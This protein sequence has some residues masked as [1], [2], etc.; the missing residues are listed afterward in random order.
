MNVQNKH[1]TIFQNKNV[2]LQHCVV[3]WLSRGAQHF[4][5]END[6]LST[7]QYEF[8]HIGNCSYLVYDEM[9]WQYAQLL[10][11]LENC[12]AKVT[13]SEHIAVVEWTYHTIQNFGGT[14]NI[15]VNACAILPI[16]NIIKC[17]Y[18]TRVWQNFAYFTVCEAQKTDLLSMTNTK[19]HWY[20][21][22]LSRL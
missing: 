22:K 1:S 2:D 18:F 20:S 3:R 16:T 11:T 10:L 9:W 6:P 7:V 19:L 4:P 5:R 8:H 13:K 15:L 21:L 12:V 17:T 14:K